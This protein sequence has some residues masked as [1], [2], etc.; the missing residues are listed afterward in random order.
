M[1]GSAIR[2]MLGEILVGGV[3]DGLLH[4][5]PGFGTAEKLIL[6]ASAVAAYAVARVVLAV[7]GLPTVPGYSA[8]LLGQSWYA[9]P[10][11]TVLLFVLTLLARPLVRVRFDAPLFCAATGL[12]ALPTHGGD[13]RNALLDAGSPSVYLKMAV[14]QV[15]LAGSLLAA[16]AALYRPMT[17]SQVV[18]D[19]PEDLP[20]DRGWTVVT[21]GVITLTLLALLGL[22]P[23][24]GQAILSAALAGGLGALIT[25]RS[26]RVTGSVWY[27]AGLM[28]SGVVAYLWTYVRPDGYQIGDVS[29]LLAGPARVLPLHYVTAGVAGTLYGYWVARA[30]AGEAEEA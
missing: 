30:W 2:N 27:V 19:E 5:Q 12:L 26:Q 1:A 6:T 8:L 18:V 15:L 23:L 9:W 16:Y 3:R 17:V 20:S 11:F 25:F 28:A 24:K 14:E 4:D 29:G 22:S 7:L 13:V 10:A 21:Q